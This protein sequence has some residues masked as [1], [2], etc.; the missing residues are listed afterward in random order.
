MIGW[1]WIIASASVFTC[2]YSRGMGILLCS[3]DLS[4]QTLQKW[5]KSWCVDQYSSLNSDL[6]WTSELSRH[7]TFLWPTLLINYNGGRGL[8]E[9]RKGGASYLHLLS[10]LAYTYLCMPHVVLNKIWNPKRETLDHY[11]WGSAWACEVKDNFYTDD[12]LLL[13]YKESTCTYTILLVYVYQRWAIWYII[14][15]LMV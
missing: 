1:R 9:Q 11:R 2:W 4:H 6:A 12:I 10:M 3:L 5:M 13:F 15:Q 8:S 14:W 7:V